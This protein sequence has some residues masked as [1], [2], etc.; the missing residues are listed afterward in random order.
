VHTEKLSTRMRAIALAVLV[1]AALVFSAGAAVAAPSE[2]T[3]GVTELQTLLDASGGTLDGHLKTVLKGST[4][5][6]IPVRVL[7]VT[8]GSQTGPSSLSAL[9]VFEAYGPEIDA[10][11]GGI[12]GIA[13]GM[14]GSPIYVDDGG[15]DKLIGALSYGDSM[16]LGGTGLA[17]PIEAMALVEAEQDVRPV[18][19]QSLDE[20]VLTGGGLKDRVIVTSSPEE[21]AADA[22]SGAIV[23]E[24]LAS[25]YMG[26][27]DAQS[28]IYRD[29]SAFQS[30]RGVKLIPSGMSGMTSSYNAPFQPGSAIAGL[31]TRGDLWSGGVGTVTYVNGANVLA[32]GH[33]MYWQGATNLFMTN[34]W[35]DYTWPSTYAPYKVA[36]PAA[37]RG[38]I[39]QDRM[40]A[41]LGVDGAFPT[42]I[43]I[44]AKAT[45]VDTGETAETTVTMPARAINSSS[46]DFWG[47]PTM[48]AY[49]AG[50][51]LYDQATTDGSAYTTTTV[52]VSDGTQTY[53]IQRT[54]IVDAESDI[55][56]AVVNDVDQ[57]VTQL[58]NVGANG[59]ATP[60]IQSVHVDSEISSERRL[61]EIVGV[62]VPGGLRRGT[63]RVVVSY[64]EWG[65]PTTQTVDV[66]LAIPSGVPLAGTLDAFG[67]V[68]PIL[69]E[70]E[71][72]DDEAVLFDYD[73]E[74][75][76]SGSI[77]RTTV[78][79]IASDLN[80]PAWNGDLTV[81]FQP[82]DPFYDPENEDGA[83]PK[84]YQPV[85]AATRLDAYLVGAAKM[86]APVMMADFSGSSDAIAYN[87]YTWVTGMMLGVEG[88]TGTVKVT[89]QY[90]GESAVVTV[91]T[92]KVTE[93]GLFFA[94]LTGLKKNATVRLYY[95]G[96]AETL[97]ASMTLYAR[98]SAK[99]ALKSS[100]SKIK[101]GK[102]VT[103]SATVLPS[104]TN[105]SV[106]FERYSGGRW[107]ILTTRTLVGG[108]AAY[109]Y[110][111]PLGTNK[112]R[113]R[114]IGSTRNSWGKSSTIT[115]KVVK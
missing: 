8:Y 63:N 11:D 72:T 93:D 89:R 4:I 19:I 77:D 94:K 33:P 50:S 20:P 103:L 43:P 48:S 104:D 54:N 81:S 46:G 97:P 52:V 37:L 62:A 49:V 35:V 64:L 69:D 71:T 15:T 73:E 39:T 84:T 111:A 40:A 88:S 101:R 38:T 82:V 7:A 24:P 28:K 3:L 21:Y 86:Q 76:A 32:F 109:R 85:E 22:A 102:T 12:G 5:V 96:D 16:T 36:R 78:K 47:L 53:T 58:Q 42:E 30:K 61:A 29:Y 65:N 10:E 57:I 90:A 79:E 67:P 6:D 25:M 95:S 2:P 13:S 92:V 110:K 105:G 26:G 34:A 70:E 17:T 41:I 83:P 113:A 60:F 44:T 55:A 75:A 114:T 45:N 100:A 14:S 56:Y 51:R 91:A 59:I 31:A 27:V 66:M 80:E 112:L 1:T 68:G 108:K 106:R 23:A 9:I 74:F 18:T 107:K 98:V 99:V 87:G 115:V